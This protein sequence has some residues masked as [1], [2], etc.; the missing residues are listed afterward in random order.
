MTT[1]VAFTFAN[2]ARPNLEL[3]DRFPQLAR[4]AERCEALPAFLESSA[5]RGPRI[6][7]LA[8][9]AIRLLRRYL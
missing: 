2:L 9:S 8:V 7:E 1:T 4:F 6:D 3:A 5:S